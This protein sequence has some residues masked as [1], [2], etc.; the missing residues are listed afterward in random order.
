VELIRVR[1]IG[2]LGSDARVTNGATEMHVR[3]SVYRARGLPA[4]FRQAALEGQVCAGSEVGTRGKG[5]REA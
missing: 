1:R 3:E 2:R 4:N 5:A